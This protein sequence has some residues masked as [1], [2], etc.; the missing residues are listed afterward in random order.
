MALLE[1]IGR[2]RDGNDTSRRPSLDSQIAIEPLD[3]AKRPSKIRSIAELLAKP[4]WQPHH[5][6]AFVVGMSRLLGGAAKRDSSGGFHKVSNL[7]VDH[8]ND[9]AYQ[10]AHQSFRGGEGF[11]VFAG[12]DWLCLLPDGQEQE[13]IDNLGSATVDW[14]TVGINSMGGAGEGIQHYSVMRFPS[15][16]PEQRIASVLFPEGISLKDALARPVRVE[17]SQVREICRRIFQA[18]ETGDTS[19]YP[20]EF[21][22]GVLTGAPAA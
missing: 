11:I 12:P 4:D 22:D 9:S 15:D 19:V 14:L 13:V 5:Y 17:H 18:F 1:L 8:D 20:Y 7:L 16:S 10:F 3:G 6:A 2:L 21:P